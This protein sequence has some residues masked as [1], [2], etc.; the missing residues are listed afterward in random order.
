MRFPDLVHHDPTPIHL[1]LWRVAC[2]CSVVRQD[3]PGS[4]FF[5]QPQ[6]EPQVQA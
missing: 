5:F 6:G 4:G 2:L 1:A 3:A